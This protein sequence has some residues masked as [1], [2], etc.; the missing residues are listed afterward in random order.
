MKNYFR[1]YFCFV[2]LLLFWGNLYPRYALTEDIYQVRD[3]QNRVLKKDPAADYARISAAGAGEVV[4]RFA[5]I[6]KL[7]E[8]FGEEKTYDDR[9]N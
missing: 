6:E 2:V 3:T 7:D 4:I 5:L 8:W 9:G 1:T